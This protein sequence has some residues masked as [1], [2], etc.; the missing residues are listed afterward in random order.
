MS[1]KKSLDKGKLGERQWAQY[2]R[3]IWGFVSHRGRQFSGSPDSPDVKILALDSRIHWEVKR[4]E[5]LSLYAA[6]AQA[7]ADAGDKIPVVAHRRSRKDW[8]VVMRA[9]D[10]PDFAYVFKKA[11]AG[12]N[13]PSP[14]V[15]RRHRVEAKKRLKGGLAE[16]DK[17]M[18]KTASSNGSGGSVSGES[19][20]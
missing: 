4:T 3:E 1:G 20:P 9:A 18:S 12:A 11:H 19:D 15:L 13:L 16:L 6:M 5:T 10:V 8:L 14:F 17:V 7:T 2:A